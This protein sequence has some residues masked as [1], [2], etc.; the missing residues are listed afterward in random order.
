MISK[1]ARVV[2]CRRK[3][4][5]QATGLT[6]RLPKSRAIRTMEAWWLSQG[7]RIAM[8]SGLFSGLRNPGLILF[9]GLLA[10]ALLAPGSVNA[11]SPS[12]VGNSNIYTKPLPAPVLPPAG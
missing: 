3:A 4:T 12:A 7:G 8:S 11:Q 6:P 9:V 1:R 5:G 10:G 2:T